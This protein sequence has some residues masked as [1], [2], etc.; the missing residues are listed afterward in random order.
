MTSRDRAPSKERNR[1]DKLEEPDSSEAMK[2]KLEHSGMAAKTIYVDV[3]IGPQQM[4]S[5]SVRWFH[6]RKYIYTIFRVPFLI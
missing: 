3:S 5:L 6:D 1:S 2:A 4:L